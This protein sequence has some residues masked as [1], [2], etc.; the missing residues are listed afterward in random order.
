MS[1]CM[2]DKRPAGALPTPHLD[3]YREEFLKHRQCLER[4]REY[5]SERAIMDVEKALTRVIAE[6][7]YLC[8]DAD[9]D[10]VVS[11]L[12]RKFDVVTRLS[13]WTDPTN[14]H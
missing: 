9:A 11:M 13:A 6:L 7:E 3:F 1:E 12:L 10:R 14:A 4:H 5:Y 8:P 2:S